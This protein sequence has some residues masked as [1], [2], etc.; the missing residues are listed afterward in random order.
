M[1]TRL[2]LSLSL[3]LAA[4]LSA[5]AQSG[6]QITR[7]GIEITPPEAHQETRVG[8]A[9]GFR[10]FGRA[11]FFATPSDP[12]LPFHGRFAFGAASSAAWEAARK[13][14]GPRLPSRSIFTG[15]LWSWFD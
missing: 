3:I 8:P 7:D 14:S 4:T 1:R 15:A 6:V 11:G 10:R 5:P 2:C 13:E 9:T 12:G